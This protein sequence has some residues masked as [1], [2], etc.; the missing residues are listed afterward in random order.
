MGNLGRAKV[1]IVGVAESDIGIAA[2]GMTPVDLMAQGVDRALSDCGIS[3][4][5]VDGVF[6]AATQMN[7]PVLNLCE[8]LG[9]Q[10]RYMDGTHIGGA[11]FEAHVGHAMAAIESGACSVA[12]VAY[13]STQR[14]AGRST[15]AP[16]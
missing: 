9:I 2:P 16:Q 13:G 15:A 12:V 4:R 10:P 14:S 11:S 5:D 3:L 7:M 8:Y 6:A 1:A